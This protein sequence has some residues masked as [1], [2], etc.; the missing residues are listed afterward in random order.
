[1]TAI[2]GTTIGVLGGDWRATVTP[3]GDVLPWGDEA[4]LQWAIAA[5]DRW[6]RPADET[7]V[8][9]RA[10]DG[11]P[12]IETRVRVPGG[13]AVHRVWATA[14]GV[15]VVEVENDSSM[16]FAVAFTRPDVLTSRT[17]ADVPIQGIDLPPGSFIVPIGHRSSARIGLDH[18]GTGAGRL[19]DDLPTAL[20]V[21]RGWTTITDRASRLVLPDAGWSEAVVAAR[22]AVTLEGPPDPADDP[23]GFLIAVGELV[24]TGDAAEPWVIDIAEEAEPLMRKHRRANGMPWDVAAALWATAR[25]LAAAGESR[26]SADVAAAL[27]SS[28]ERT[29][30][31]LQLPTGIRCVPWVEQHFARPVTDDLASLL[32][33]GFPDGWLGAG[34][35]GYRIPLGTTRAVSFALRWHGERPAVLWEVE[36]QAGLQLDGGG[37]DPA[38]HTTEPR[39]EALWAAP[40]GGDLNATS[41]S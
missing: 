19:P 22:C 1:M 23:V 13:D 32:P 40:R 34:V 37:A 41:F 28:P 14:E 36:G 31:D 33:N 7:A 30:V 25:V 24:R 15:T 17:P 2:T 18:R 3:W 9:Q 16:P 20:Q 10:V 8:R 12:V 4:P 6:H 26:G 39:G 35:E 11:T 38:W 5:D 21:A 29:T 27:A